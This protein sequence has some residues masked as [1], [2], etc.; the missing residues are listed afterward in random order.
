MIHHVATVLTC[1]RG[2]RCVP[3]LITVTS[4]TVWTNVNNESLTAF[5]WNLFL[6]IKGVKTAFISGCDP[7][8]ILL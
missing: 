6:L 4:G 1:S 7:E 5:K 3:E 2:V 8:A